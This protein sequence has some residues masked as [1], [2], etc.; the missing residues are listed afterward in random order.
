MGILRPPISL[1]T[2]LCL[3]PLTNKLPCTALN[4]SRLPLWQRPLLLHSIQQ[5]AH[6][7]LSFQSLQPMTPLI[8]LPMS[9]TVLSQVPAR[10]RAP[11]TTPSA[12]S[13]SHPPTSGP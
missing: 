3:D 6:L 9:T 2:F 5:R 10:H 1:F 12:A 13:S 8:P 11:R 4:T 7:L